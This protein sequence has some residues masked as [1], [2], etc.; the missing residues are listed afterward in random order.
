MSGGR[1]EL[2]LGAGWYR[3]EHA[4]YGIPF[5][6][7]ATRF[8]RLEEQLAIITG[9]WAAPHDRPFSHDG[10]EYQVVESPALAKPVQS[11]LPIVI[12]GIGPRRTPTL[13]ARYAAEF[14]LPFVAREQVPT[15]LERVDAACAA[16]DR[17]PA[18][19]ARSA[20]LVVCIGTDEAEFTRRATSIGRE[21]D[22]LRANGVC[23]LPREAAAQVAAYRE[24]GVERFYFQVLDLSDLDHLDLIRQTLA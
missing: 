8:D 5:P 20:A 23:G 9:M 10:A 11:P 3:H 24:L 21:P 7:T 16:I 6:D 4:A 15:I 2:G 17:D 1:V 13:A 19:L 18:S 22:E 12:G 14:N